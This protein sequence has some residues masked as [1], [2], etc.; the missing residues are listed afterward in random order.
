MRSY[1]K[2]HD[3]KSGMPTKV[4]GE[5]LAYP[6]EI[7][8][9]IMG[10][11]IGT[12]HQAMADMVNQ[13][14]KTDYT[15]E[16]MKGFYARNK[17]NSGLTGYYHKGHTPFNKRKTKYWVGGEETQFK[18]GH[19]PANHKPV[20]S[21]RINVDGYTEIKTAEP[22][23][24]RLKHNAIW[25]SHNGPIP[26]G[27]CVLFGDGDKQNLDVNNL[28]LVSRKQLVRLNQRGLIQNDIELTKTGIIIA[29]VISKIGE[30]KRGVS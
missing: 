9:F 18:K 6:E 13:E 7:R 14:F 16:Q 22:N 1:L 8:N 28:I 20:G 12:G 15:K 11:Y 25:E 21:E 4:K 5:G 3:L 19:T 23:K 24:W 30:R 10:C 17:L 27:S 2:N 26:K 29:D